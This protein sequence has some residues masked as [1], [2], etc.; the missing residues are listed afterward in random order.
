LGRKWHEAVLARPGA[1]RAWLSA[2]GAV[3]LLVLAF[4]LVEQRTGFLQRG[5]DGRPGLLD[6]RRD[7]TTDLYGWDKVAIE[8]ERRGILDDPGS[9]LFTR[10]WYQTAQVA[11]AIHMK[12]PVLCYN[13][14]DPR[15]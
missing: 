2:G 12:R 7:P 8:L 9:F 15:G 1:T 14:D 10:M 4:T 3:T 13:I 11:H 6:V 5:W